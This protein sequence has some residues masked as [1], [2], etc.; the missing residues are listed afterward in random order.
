MHE[1]VDAHSL[2]PSLPPPLP[3]PPPLS[4]SQTPSHPHI[5]CLCCNVPWIAPASAITC[6]S[7]ESPVAFLDFCSNTYGAC[8]EE[9]GAPQQCA[10]VVWRCLDIEVCSYPL[11]LC[12]VL[13]LCMC[14]TQALVVNTKAVSR[15]SFSNQLLLL[16]AR[17]TASLVQSLSATVC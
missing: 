3:P 4:P 6:P 14:T 16:C 13:R 11:L 15:E 8:Y 10:R 12:H 5:L 17:K 7:I 1:S 9:M 2:T